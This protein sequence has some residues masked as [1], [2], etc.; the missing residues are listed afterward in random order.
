MVDGI[1]R[2]GATVE[3]LPVDQARPCDVG[4]CWGVKK[5]G[6]RANARRMLV[7]KR[8]Y[9]GDRFKWTS[10]GW[11]GLNGFADFCNTNMPGD[12]WE[13]HFAHLMRPWRTEERGSHVLIMGQ[14]PGDASLRGM[15]THDW[16]LKVAQDIRARGIDAKIRRHP[17]DATMNPRLLRARLHGRLSYYDMRDWDHAVADAKW[18]VAYNSNSAVDAVL[19][20]IPT[21]TCD[22]GT[23][24]WPITDHVPHRRPAMRDRT[25][26]ARDLAYTQWSIEE[27]ASGEAWDHIKQGVM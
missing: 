11:G 21:V 5:P 8:G 9:I 26:W 24:A 16:C 25:Q 22:Q 1:R 13:R 7:L 3:V 17:K 2:H 27:L 18:I 4:L 19:Q 12:R 6:V 14:V 15:D 10:V 20:G 23:M